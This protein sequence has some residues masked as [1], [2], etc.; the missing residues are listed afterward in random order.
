MD[1]LPLFLN[2]KHINCLVVGAGNVA[3]RK[4]E[5]LVG[6]GARIRVVAKSVIAD[7]ANLLDTNNIPFRKGE[8]KESDVSDVNLVIAATNNSKVNAQIRKACERS[9]VWI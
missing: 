5:V 2:G 8:F 7:V 9:N 6:S 3:L 1:S 4:L